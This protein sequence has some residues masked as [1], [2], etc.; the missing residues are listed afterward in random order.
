MLQ[1]LKKVFPFVVA[2]AVLEIIAFGV[3]VATSPSP[4]NPQIFMWYSGLLK[5][6]LTPPNI[7]FGIVW[8]LLY[9]LMAIAAVLVAQSSHPLKRAALALFALQ[10]LANLSWSFVFFRLQATHASLLLIGVIFLLV[11][12]TLEIFRRVRPLAALLLIPYLAWIAFASYLMFDIVRLN[13]VG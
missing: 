8:P 9:A 6:P 10:L 11:A 7:T 12:A 3:G 4:E 1:N 2:V 13:G 5:S